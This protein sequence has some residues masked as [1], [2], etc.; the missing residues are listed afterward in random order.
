M[1]MH[2]HWLKKKKKQKKKKQIHICFWVKKIENEKLGE[3]KKKNL[4]Q[5]TTKS[6]EVVLNQWKVLLVKKLIQ[7][8]ISILLNFQVLV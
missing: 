3:K 8:I 2:F 5:I 4:K 7:K 6:N 1:F